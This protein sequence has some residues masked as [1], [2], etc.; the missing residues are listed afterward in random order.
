MSLGRLPLVLLLAAAH[1]ALA[2]PTYTR[3]EEPPLWTERA[4]GKAP[5]RSNALIAMGRGGSE[6]EA[7]VGAFC[8][9]AGVLKLRHRAGRS[10]KG[11]D[12]ISAQVGAVR[13]RELVV[14]G[15]SGEQVACEVSVPGFKARYATKWVEGLDAP[16]GALTTEPRGAPLAQLIAEAEKAGVEL[17]FHVGSADT[18][19]GIIIEAKPFAE[20]LKTASAPPPP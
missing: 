13:L 9:L 12:G 11:Q 3:G 20:A 4:T 6:A 14:A 7:L 5:G 2:A 17:Q 16:V 10:D 1:A 15:E 19:A 18:V 8:S